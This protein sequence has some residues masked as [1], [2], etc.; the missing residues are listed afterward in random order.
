MERLPGDALRIDAP[1]L[2]ALCVAA[3]G[4]LLRGGGNIGLREAR[5][6]LFELGAV[7]RLQAE[8]VDTRLGAAIG[9]GEVDAR[10]LEHPLRVVGLL[11]RR[12][13]AEQRR[14]ETDALLEVMHADVDVEALHG[15][16]LSVWSWGH[17]R[18][19]RSSS[20]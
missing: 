12:L 9:N 4:A 3:A 18:G 17:R 14:I 1:V 6:D 5:V 10:I 15:P 13:G 19:H 2:V 20:P 7:V 8:M 11:H 16:F